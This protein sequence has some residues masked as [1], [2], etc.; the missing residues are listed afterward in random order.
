M[1]F[2]RIFLLKAVSSWLSVLQSNEQAKQA[3]TP[4]SERQA[5]L[6]EH[7]IFGKPMEISVEQP[8][9]KPPKYWFP[10]LLMVPIPEAGPILGYID[11]SYIAVITYVIGSVFYVVDSFYLWYSIN[12]D[13]TD[14]GGNPAIYLNTVSAGLFVLNAWFCFL[15]WHLQKKQ[16]SLMNMYVE[17]D[18]L[19]SLKI[20]EVSKRISTYYFFNNLFFMIAALIF[21]LQGVWMEDT[22]TDPD[23][24]SSDQM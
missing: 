2:N 21:V 12:P 22:R 16:L 3:K 7:D 14:D 5:G 18:N 24:C 1:P 10:G 15:D 19:G 4:K 13:Y 11:I 20:A 6:L 17:N 9:R 8:I 23:G